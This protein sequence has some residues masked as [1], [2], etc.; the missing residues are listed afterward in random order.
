PDFFFSNWVDLGSGGGFPGLVIAILSRELCPAAKVTL[1]E[2]DLRKATFLREAIRFLDLTACVIT[3]RIEHLSQMNADILSAR[4][5]APFNLLCGF[6]DRHLAE[7]GFALFPKGAGWRSEVEI[8]RKHWNFN[9][10]V[11]LSKTDSS[12]VV[13]KVRGLRHV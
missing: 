2:A 12:A 11:C 5:L 8:A 6:A 3:E 4:A 10:E 1:V 13:L 9:L 7:G